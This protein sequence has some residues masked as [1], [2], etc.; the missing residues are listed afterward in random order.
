MDT[1]AVVAAMRSPSGASAAMIRASA[2]GAGDVVADGTSGD[3][4]R[5]R[6]PEIRTPGGIRSAIEAARRR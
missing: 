4:V 3:G 6:L 2:T 1:D 5:S